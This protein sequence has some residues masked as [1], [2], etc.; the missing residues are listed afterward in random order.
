MNM[1]RNGNA[2]QKSS[3][4]HDSLF[5]DA[6]Q[7]FY[8]IDGTFSTRIRQGA[9]CA[10]TLEQYASWWQVDLLGVFNIIALSITTRFEAGRPPFLLFF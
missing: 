10:I 4:H 1:A 8:A 3:H 9:R 2:S 6:D 7:A 5:N